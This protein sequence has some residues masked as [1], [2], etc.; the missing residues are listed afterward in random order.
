MLGGAS[1]FV[2]GLSRLATC[3]ACTVCVAAFAEDL[4]PHV[5][6]AEDEPSP[7]LAD[8]SRDALANAAHD[9][10]DDN[11]D[12]DDN[13]DDVRSER[14]YIARPPAVD[15]PSACQPELQNLIRLA[16][17]VYDA[18]H[19]ERSMAMIGS[20]SVPATSVYRAGSRYG[21]FELLEVRPH[22]VLLSSNREE[23]PC[24]LKMQRPSANP[25][26]PAA[27]APPADQAKPKRE[28]KKAFSDEELK[29]GIQ[30]VGPGV[31]RVNR[32]VLDQALARAPLLARSIRTRTK[33]R[34]GA[35]VG[36]SLTKIEEGGLFDHLGLK[37]GD[38]LK[39]VNGFDMSSVD[40]MLSARTQLSSASTLSLSLT[41]GGQ[42]ATLEYHVH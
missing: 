37:K 28:R 34:H 19:P 4:P 2:R 21:G 9:D 35:A 11:D 5:N 20:A 33:K 40:G 12:H 41:R 22:A 6:E 39:T 3:C 36:M 10:S 23:S 32:A 30:Q 31:Y 16:G 27:A 14:E 17:T 42:P 38:V 26:P 25:P 7:L 29:Q 1:R 18:R 24:W 15:R 13:D 8:T